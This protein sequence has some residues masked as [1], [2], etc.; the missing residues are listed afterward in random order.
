MKP[1]TVIGA[2]VFLIVAAAHAYRVYTGMAVTVGT[3]DIPMW[4]SWAGAVGA[5]F[6][7]VMLLTESRR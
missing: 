5:A 7:G 2:L 4:V 3:L 1:F 6:L